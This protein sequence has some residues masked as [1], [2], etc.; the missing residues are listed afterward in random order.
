M[1]FAAEWN[2][3]AAVLASAP[4]RRRLG[5]TLP[6]RH[7]AGS[8]GDRG[9]GTPV[10]WWVRDDI[11]AARNPDASGGAALTTTFAARERAAHA[12]RC[13]ISGDAVVGEAAAV[14]ALVES[15]G[16][17]EGWSVS[18]NV[19]VKTVAAGGCGAVFGCASPWQR[20]HRAGD[21]AGGGVTMYNFLPLLPGGLFA[22]V[23]VR[24][25]TIG[26]AGDGRVSCV[27]ECWASTV[28]STAVAAR[29]VV[30]QRERA[31]FEDGRFIDLSCDDGHDKSCYVLPTLGRVLVT[32]ACAVP[33]VFDAQT[34]SCRPAAEGEE[35]RKLTK[36]LGKRFRHHFGLDV[37]AMEAHLSG[38]DVWYARVAYSDAC[39]DGDG[40]APWDR[41]GFVIPSTL[42]RYAVAPPVAAPP[43]DKDV[44][45]KQFQA[46]VAAGFGPLSVRVSDM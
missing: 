42:L 17:F 27:A 3:A 26:A 2:C 31:R 44:I 46:S 5:T 22:A 11:V 10:A 30:P 37:Q 15:G 24:K 29:Q 40:A 45:L 9:A 23:S 21:G 13:A 43:S 19:P 35:E 1:P 38:A 32:G 28:R 6:P 18:A 41:L 4:K 33:F 8:G 39:V 36:L 34:E 25:A 14:T 16:A 7:A 20:G 12:A